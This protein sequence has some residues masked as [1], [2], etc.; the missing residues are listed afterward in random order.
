[1]TTA[2]DYFRDAVSDSLDCIK[3]DIDRFATKYYVDVANVGKF[4]VSIEDLINEF[5]E[6]LDARERAEI[7]AAER[8]E[9][10]DKEELKR[11]NAWYEGQLL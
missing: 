11:L 9:K 4:V 2:G 3:I 10:E 5:C 6:L 8:Q 7:L 1:M